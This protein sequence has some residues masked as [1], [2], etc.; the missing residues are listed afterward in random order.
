[1]LA[2]NRIF[3]VEDETLVAMLVEDMLDSIGLEHVA[4]ASRLDQGLKLAREL[5]F[6]AAVLDVNLAGARSFPIA[7]VLKE[8]NIPFVFATGYG[9]EGI[10]EEHRDVPVIGKPFQA[11]DLKA[12][13]AVACPQDA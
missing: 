2:Y 5:D 11:R 13:L 12:A 3:L 7:D 10:A 4:T 9:R 6:D 8:R 1:V